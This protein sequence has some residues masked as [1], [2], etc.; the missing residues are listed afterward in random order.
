V[1]GPSVSCLTNASTPAWCASAIC[2]AVIDAIG[3][4]LAPESAAAAWTVPP[5]AAVSATISMPFI[6][7]SAW[8]GMVHSVV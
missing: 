1:F 2:C 5:L 4:A 3:A 7:A 8:P 6:P